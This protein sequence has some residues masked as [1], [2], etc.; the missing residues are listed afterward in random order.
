MGYALQTQLPVKCVARFHSIAEAKDQLPQFNPRVVI[1]D[2]RL[3]EESGASLV[4]ELKGKMPETRW[5]LFTA[6]PTPSVLREALPAGIHGCVSKSADYEELAHAMSELLNGGSYFCKESLKS[7]GETIDSTNRSVHLTET[8]R[9]ILRCVAEG[10]EPKEIA[11]EIKLTAKT[12]HNYLVII[13]QKLSLGSMVDLARFAV[14]QG[15]A[16]PR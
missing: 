10:L 5:L 3:G 1:T 15:I 9:A 16:R 2:W 13:R 11:G 8:E 4:R 14:D 6:W 12:V 7:L